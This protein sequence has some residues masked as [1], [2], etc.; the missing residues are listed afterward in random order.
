MNKQVSARR[1]GT[2]KIGDYY[3]NRIG[4]GAMRLTG[5]GVWGQPADPEL[6]QQVLTAAVNADINFIDTADAYGPFV[7]EQMIAKTLHPYDGI[8]VATKGGL[9]RPS[10]DQWEA[11]CS[12]EHLRE[13]CEA[14]LERLNVS[15]ID[16]YQMHTVDSSVDFGD[17]FKALLQLQEAGK[18]RH[19]GLSNIEPEHLKQALKLGNIVS[20]QNNYN[21]GN[22][23][24]EDVLALCQEH[25]ITFIPYFPI[26]GGGVSLTTNEHLIAIA[27]EHGATVP[28]VA[29]A[30]LLQHSPV[31]LPI[32]GTSSLDHLHENIASAELQLTAKNI[33]QIDQIAGK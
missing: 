33:V 27:N 15:R 29:L 20:V 28:Q 24:H 1:A 2:I 7:S 3:V 23:E 18:I 4:F 26:G 31:T 17:S 10:A 9:T 21:A 8:V 30:W 5:P 6:A 13:A 16:L 14:S 12:P 11:D 22:R 32:P 25:D 19:I